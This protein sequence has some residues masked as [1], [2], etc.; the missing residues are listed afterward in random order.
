[1]RLY[2]IALIALSLAGCAHKDVT[3]ALG[4]EFDT[5]TAYLLDHFSIEESGGQVVTHEGELEWNPDAR[6]VSLPT[7]WRRIDMH[8]NW[9]GDAGKL[10][11]A[12]Q[13]F[14]R[15]DYKGD[16]SRL[17]FIDGLL[18]NTYSR[19][20]TDQRL[21]M[22]VI[23]AIFEDEAKTD[24]MRLSFSQPVSPFEHVKLGRAEQSGAGQSAAA[25]QLKS[26]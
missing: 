5:P 2:M 6:V 11:L 23:Q 24:R 3:A 14:T 10:W 21:G 16:R 18:V 7:Q 1:M 13:G 8:V 22:I 4:R 20:I 12:E 17:T 9:L 15:P 26:N 19:S 25:P